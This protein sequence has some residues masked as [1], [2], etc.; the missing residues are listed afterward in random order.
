VTA[1]TL[2]RRARRELNS[3]LRWIAR[4]NPLAAQALLDAVLKAAERIGQHPKI[5]VL[6]PD[7][8]TTDRYRFVVLT[9]FRYL[10][11]RAADR[12]PPVIVRIVHGA[13][14]LP[15]LLRNLT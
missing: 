13:R 3:A 1:A 2:S 9:G 12:N 7:L 6:R 10:I 15:R 8:T 4:D 14:D 5:G 11:V